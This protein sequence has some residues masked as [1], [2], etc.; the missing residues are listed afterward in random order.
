MKE[1]ISFATNT[2]AVIIAGALEA[3]SEMIII[4]SEPS[5]RL[6]TDG[7]VARERVLETV[8]FAISPEAMRNLAE[9]LVVVAADADALIASLSAGLSKP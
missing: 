9:K 5:Y 8:R 6:T 3:R 1:F 4:L 7:T 2:H